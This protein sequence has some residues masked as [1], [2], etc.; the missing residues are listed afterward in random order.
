MYCSD[1]V[2]ANLALL[3]IPFVY[4][5]DADAHGQIVRELKDRLGIKPH[6]QL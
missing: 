4:K 1:S 3:L 2:V 6:E 5:L